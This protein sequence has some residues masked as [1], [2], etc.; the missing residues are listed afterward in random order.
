[1]VLTQKR[2]LEPIRAV[3]ALKPVVFFLDNCTFYHYHDLET[4]V[5]ETGNLILFNTLYNSPLNAIE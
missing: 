3:D 2:Y 5:L 1:M 4:M